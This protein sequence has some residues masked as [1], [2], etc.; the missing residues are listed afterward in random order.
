[1]YLIFDTET[2]GLPKKWNAPVSDTDNWPRCIQI[3]WQLHDEMGNLIEHED[4]LV[5][6]DGFNIPYDAE[7]IHGISTELAEK[8]GISIEEVL[9]LFKIALDK[10]KY[11]VGQNVGFD[12][13]IMGAE[14]FRYNHSNPFEEVPILDTCTEKTA[15]LCQLPGGRGGKF[16][17]PTLTEL[18]YFLFKQP[19]KEAHNATADVEATTRCFFE[20]LRKGIFTQEELGVSIDYFR[21]FTEANPKEI[22]PIGLKHINLKK[23]SEKIAKNLAAQQDTSVSDTDLNKNIETLEEIE[24][25]HLHNH[26]QFSVLQSTIKVKDLISSAAAHNMSA[27]AITDHANMMGAFHFVKEIK[28]HNKAVEESLANEEENNENKRT[29]KPIIGCEFFVCEDHQNKNVKDYGYQMVFLAKNKNG[30]H[31]LAKMSSLAYTDGFYYVPRIDKKIIETYKEDLIV[32]SGNLYGEISSK[33]L[34]IGEKQAEEAL[35]WWKSEF[36][37]DFYLEIMRHGQE[38]EDR[39]NKVLVAFAE[40]HHVKL[41]ATNNTY[42]CAKE[43][44]DA[45]DILLC[46]KDGEK[47]ATPIGRGRGY[48]YGLPNQEYYFKS[49]EEM[50]NLF[51]DLPESIINIQEIVDKIEPYELAREVLLPKFE[52][53]E[54]FLVK[55]DEIDGGKRGEN[56]YLRHITYKGAEKRYEVISDDIRERIDFELKTIENSGYP[57]YFLI[58]EDFIREARNMDV[59]VGPGRGSAAGSVVAYCLSI[60]NIDPLKYDLLFERFL[61]PDRVSMPDIDIDFD[62]EGRGR[63]MDY[64]IEKYG[65]N[66][67]AQIITYGTM[68]AK[69]SIRDTARVLD[70][71]LHDADRIAKLIPTMSKLSKIFG[72]PESD[73]KKRFRTDELE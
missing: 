52:I 55:E 10:T 9:R 56:N 8:N 13:N 24:F 60:T 22:S 62:D 53:P 2:T 14:F 15:S 4:Y 70:L 12:V 26:S 28:A 17:L 47:Q 7:Q 61:N 11:V 50:K 25:V 31:N 34:N 57:G 49:E 6:P 3:A 21:K 23:A 41:V 39:A 59:S 30:Y 69:S 54:S 37:D 18:H 27:V 66:Q 65:S 42:Y 71:P 16:K 73:L 72:I 1:M 32:L 29:I 64:V 51:K 43:D 48:R 63:V 58:V 38:D 19:F 45:H 46:V 40:K 36:Q 68:A 67:V 44:A 33:I 5:K 35:L 20:L